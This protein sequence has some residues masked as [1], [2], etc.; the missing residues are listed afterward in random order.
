MTTRR[1]A[2]PAL[3]IWAALVVATL[4]S[5]ARAS[6]SGSDTI[7]KGSEGFFAGALPPDSGLY[8]VLYFNDYEADRFNDDHGNASVPGFD[9][10]ARVA[11]ALLFYMSDIKVAGGRLGFFAIGSFVSLKLKLKTDAGRSDQDGLGD[12]TV[13][14]VLGWKVGDFHPAIAADIVVPVGNYRASRVLNPGTNHYAVRPIVSLSY[15]PASGLELSAKI[16]Y[17]FNARN[18]ATDYS[19][20]ELLHFH[21]SASYPVTRKLRLGLNGH[22]FKQTTDDRQ[23]GALVNGDGNRGR[24]IAIGQALHYERG[25]VGLDFKVLKEFDARNRAEGTSLWPQNRQ[26]FLGGIHNLALLVSPSIR[27]NCYESFT[28]SLG[29]CSGGGNR[30]SSCGQQSIGGRLGWIPDRGGIPVV[31]NRDDGAG[32]SGDQHGRA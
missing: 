9:L 13:G 4:A 18:E 26:A 16:T 22:Y 28:S 25:K 15:L 29:F 24:V 10:S 23:F 31:Y 20:G 30:G 6:E 5:P 3:T 32:C 7:G 1:I 19:S 21:Y 14:P 27:R 11:A 8:G 2:A 17:T 12:L